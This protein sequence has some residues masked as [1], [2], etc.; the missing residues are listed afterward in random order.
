MISVTFLVETPI[1]YISAMASFRAFSERQPLSQESQRDLGLVVGSLDHVH[2]P[3]SNV[4]VNACL[5]A[6]EIRSHADNFTFKNKLRLF[7]QLFHADSQDAG[8]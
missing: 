2:H 3:E 4:G 7:G 5:V 6:V 1:T 8:R